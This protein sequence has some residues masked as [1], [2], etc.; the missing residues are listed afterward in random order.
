METSQNFSQLV[1]EETQK[2]AN[3]TN[4]VSLSLTERLMQL[5]T[6]RSSRS[7]AVQ[8]VARDF[9]GLAAQMASLDQ[10]RGKI[11]GTL[12]QAAKEREEVMSLLD[13]VTKD[14]R[15]QQNVVLAG[16]NAQ[17]EQQQKAD[18]VLANIRNDLEAVIADTGSIKTSTL[19]SVQK[20]IQVM[21]ADQNQKLEGAVQE[22]RR[23]TQQSIE[24]VRSEAA[25]EIHMLRQ[26]A[27]NGLVERVRVIETNHA[28]QDVKD[29]LRMMQVEKAARSD[30]SQAFESL[31]TTYIQTCSELRAEIG[32]MPEKITRIARTVSEETSLRDNFYEKIMVLEQ[33]LSASNSLTI[34]QGEAADAQAEAIRA[35]ERC[36][37]DL[38]PAIKEGRAVQE[39]LMQTFEA[40][41]KM[42]NRTTTEN[43]S[44]IQLVRD[45]MVEVTKVPAEDR[46]ARDCCSKV[47][48]GLSDL[49]TVTTQKVAELRQDVLTAPKDVEE[50]RRILQVERDARCDLSQALDAYRM[51]HLQTS[52]DLRG[53]LD[54]AL[55]K[56]DR[57]ES[58]LERANRSG[59]LNQ[60]QR[61][62][63]LKALGRDERASGGLGFST[64]LRSGSGAASG[65]AVN[66]PSQGL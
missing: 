27:L 52:T 57:V 8:A 23:Q 18:V 50:L 63:E 64:P 31:R 65:L 38:W 1:K 35:V 59:A 12:D 3:M 34:R 54:R 29:A 39:D 41:R 37:Q 20:D 14:I 60:A 21:Q 48:Q 2:V 15:N 66:S 7:G 47:E 58:V 26:H 10:F 51:S 61:G 19:S 5:E 6:E 36:V 32:S 9:D 33:S 56:F 4:S 11:S 46:Y 43:R 44:E 24:V 55:E 13:S 16:L 45:R 49:R 28:D 22:V 17:K 40:D 42:Q 25:N 53:D 30:L 62:E